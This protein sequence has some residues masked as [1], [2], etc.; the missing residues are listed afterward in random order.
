M[1]DDEATTTLLQE[2]CQ[3]CVVVLERQLATQLPGGVYWNSSPQLIQE[4]K[5]SSNTNISGDRN[6]AV[7]DYE[8]QRVHRGKTGYVEGKVMYRVIKLL[9]GFL[10]CHLMRRRRGPDWLDLPVK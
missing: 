7:A 4:A 6:F 9:S 10:A 5:T 8:I 2:L 3:A 1:T